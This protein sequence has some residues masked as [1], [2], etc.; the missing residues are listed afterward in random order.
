MT[1]ICEKRLIAVQS[2]LGKTY[3]DNKYKEVLDTDK[4][5]LE[6][7]YDRKQYPDLTDEEFKS[8]KKEEIYGW[9]ENYSNFILDLI[10]K[11]D[12]RIILL[13]LKED[14]LNFLY[15]NGYNLEILIANPKFI[16]KDVFYKRFL[17]R[18]N[19]EEFCKRFDI[20]KT[21]KQYIDNKKFKV[22]TISAEIY[23]DDFLIATGE[24]LKGYT[25]SKK[26]IEYVKNHINKI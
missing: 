25:K 23:L 18:G 17:H 2:G 1:N 4:Y 20:E 8:I 10:K 13:W 5:T 9:F 14:L 12:K 22:Y 24:E 6:I 16:S 11:T 15:N 19:N 7:K 3:T 26:H 21:Y